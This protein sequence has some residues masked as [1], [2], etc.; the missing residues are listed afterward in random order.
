M[1]DFDKVTIHELFGEP[2]G[3][4]VGVAFKALCRTGDAAVITQRIGF[5]LHRIVVVSPL[6]QITTVPR[7]VG[8]NL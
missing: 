4:L 7:I 3:F 5:V 8:T 1:P 2:Y 6:P